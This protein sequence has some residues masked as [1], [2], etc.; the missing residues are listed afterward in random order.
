MSLLCEGCSLATITPYR[1]AQMTILSLLKD[2]GAVCASYLDTKVT[3]LRVRRV[4]A[5]EDLVFRL[6]GESAC[7]K[8]SKAFQA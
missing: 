1:R 2:A 5:D 7:R 4:Q 6:R 3:G 8:A